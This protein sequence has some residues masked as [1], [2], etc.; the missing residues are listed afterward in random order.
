MPNTGRPVILSPRERRTLTR[1]A[2]RDRSMTRLELQNRHAPHVSIRMVDRVLC[3]VG[4]KKWLA[5]TRP[6]LTSA[7]AKKR[8]DW[9]LARKDWTTADFQNILYSDECTVRKS[10]N[11][12]QKWVFGTPE[13]KWLADCIKP[14]AKTNEMGLMVWGCF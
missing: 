7:H 3:E 13:E 5:Q 14:R 9:A 2:Q 6:R 8:L 1:A 11:P 12:A 10:A 4:I